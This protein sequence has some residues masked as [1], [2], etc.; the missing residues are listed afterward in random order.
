MEWKEL[1]TGLGKGGDGMV[2]NSQVSDLSTW[3]EGMLLI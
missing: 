2:D 3:I 1:G